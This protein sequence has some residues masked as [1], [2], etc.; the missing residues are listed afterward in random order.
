MSINGNHYYYR[1]DPQPPI[2]M[3]HNEHP[4]SD[5]AGSSRTNSSPMRRRTSSIYALQVQAFL[6]AAEVVDSD[7]DVI[8]DLLEGFLGDAQGERGGEDDEVDVGTMYYDGEDGEGEE[9]ASEWD[10]LLREGLF[11]SPTTGS[12]WSGQAS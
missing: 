10:E 5:A 2:S 1:M 3:P 9:D 12:V 4:G 7:P 11:I 6:D 8:E